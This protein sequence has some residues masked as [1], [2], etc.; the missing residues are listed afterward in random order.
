LIIPQKEN[1]DS[2][3]I[4]VGAGPAG[5]SAAFHLAKAGYNVILLDRQAFPREKVCGDFVGPAAVKELQELGVAGLPEFQAANVINKAA[6][7]MDG[8][9]LIVSPMP[10]LE[11]LTLQGRVVPRKKLDAWVLDAA[12]RAGAKIVENVLVTGYQA[13][14]RQVR[15]KTHS[16]DGDHTYT[17]QLLIG[18]D[19]SNSIIAHALRG[20]QPNK[21]NRIVGIRAYYDGVEGAEDQA[22][23][24]FE[25]KS[26]P[27]Y[28]WLFPTGKNQAN[29]GVG[30]LLETFPTANQPKQL[31]NQLVAQDSGLKARLKNARLLGDFQT[32]PLN[33]YDS[34]SAI[35]ANRVM[36]VGE[37]AGL[38]NPLNGEGIQY[39]LQSG[40]WAAETAQTCFGNGDFSQNALNPYERR[41]ENQLGGGFMLSAL[42]VQ[43]I[44]NRAFNPLWLQTFEVMVA[45]AKHDP[46]YA[47]LTGGILA[48]LAP[49]NEALNTDFM[50]KTL[51]EATI[52]KAASII[53]ETMKNPLSAPL[54][55]VKIAQNTVEIAAGTLLNPFG[56][57]QWGLDAAMKMTQYAVAEPVPRYGR[58]RGGSWE[59]PVFK[60]T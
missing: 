44:R 35:V 49:P 6:V 10:K 3:V 22:D 50:A 30:V 34:Q 20:F 11:G 57:L 59:I 56:F 48:G 9:Q 58:R 16:T 39:A 55:A 46:A 31:L 38:V 28:C 36:L 18:A 41:V 7:Y 26:F 43:L 1:L 24:H 19:G 21:A 15:V 37:A 52:G 23:M 8:A 12:K 32:W 51:Q 54:N 27:G 17:A 14:D 40:R 4:I 29:V 13:T 45:R 53:D 47:N 42:I 33:T 2:D 60:I 25:S 5:S